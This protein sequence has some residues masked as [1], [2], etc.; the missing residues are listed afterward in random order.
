[1]SLVFSACMSAGWFVF[2]FMWWRVLLQT[3]AQPARAVRA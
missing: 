1:M 2:E 3:V